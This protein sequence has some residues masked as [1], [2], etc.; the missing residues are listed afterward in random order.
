MRDEFKE[1]AEKEAM[2]LWRLARRAEKKGEKN[3]FTKRY[4]EYFG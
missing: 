1:M 3:A 2:K 4:Y